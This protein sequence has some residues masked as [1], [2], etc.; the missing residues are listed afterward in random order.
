[1][2]AWGGVLERREGLICLEALCD[3]LC[4]LFTK[5]VELEAVNGG[6]NKVLAAANSRNGAGSVALEVFECGIGLEGLREVLGAFRTNAVALEAA[7][8]AKRGC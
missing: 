3:V 2:R 7:S 8:G 6:R 4:A 1:M 5:L